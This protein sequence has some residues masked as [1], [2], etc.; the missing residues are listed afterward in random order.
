MYRANGLLRPSG[1]GPS[2]VVWGSELPGRRVIGRLLR[3]RPT[4]EPLARK[5]VLPFRY[6]A[7]GRLLGRLLRKAPWE[8]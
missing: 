3:N 4:P 6:E 2:I 7:D 5:A 1:V 8:S